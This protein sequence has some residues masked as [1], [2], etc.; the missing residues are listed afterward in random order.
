MNLCDKLHVL[1]CNDDIVRKC[2]RIEKIGND[3]EVEKK[4]VSL[5]TFQCYKKSIHFTS[6]LVE[7]Q[8]ML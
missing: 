8:S 7:F 2:F 6:P 4:A 5:E 3:L 1:L